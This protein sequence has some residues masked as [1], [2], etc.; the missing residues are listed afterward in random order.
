M[1]RKI[2]ITDLNKVVSTY[3]LP[4]IEAANPDED[5]LKYVI[6]ILRT[7]EGVYTPRVMRWESFN[8]MP[9]YLSDEYRYDE[10]GTPQLYM[11]ECLIRDYSADWEEIECESEEDALQCVLN[12][13]ESQAQD[14]DD[15]ADFDARENADEEDNLR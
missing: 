13:F 7:P 1:Q 11:E 5:T 3:E 10:H 15:D 6:Q 2:S 9:T 8:L 14:N 12:E 4:E